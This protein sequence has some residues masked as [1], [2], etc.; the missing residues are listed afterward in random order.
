MHQLPLY[1]GQRREPHLRPV[2]GPHPVQVAI[3]R[4]PS[5]DVAIAVV[6]A[7]IA[8]A[9]YFGTKRGR[10]EVAPPA[11]V[12]D[13]ARP[14]ILLGV[15]ADSSKS[16]SGVRVVA[17]AMAV[18][19]AGRLSASGAWNAG[20]AVDGCIGSNIWASS[21]SEWHCN[22]TERATASDVVAAVGSRRGSVRIAGRTRGKI[23]TR[24]KITLPLG[25]LVLVNS[26]IIH[27]IAKL[28]RGCHGLGR[29]EIQM[30]CKTISIIR[31]HICW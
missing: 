5:A 12:A 4:R 18:V 9:E 28:A 22:S 20:G 29:I 19:V 10:P 26:C 27:R 23:W 30:H 11:G 17:L 15:R 24:E 16:D 31:R 8:I 21:F 3:P 14:Q 13:L 6:S 7:T 2:G 1:P 25:N